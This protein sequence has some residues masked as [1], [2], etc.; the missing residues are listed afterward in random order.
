[1]GAM[2]ATN[3]LKGDQNNIRNNLVTIATQDS[4]L[5][6][7]LET[8]RRRDNQFSKRANDG[9]PR[10]RKSTPGDLPY[11]YLSSHTKQLHYS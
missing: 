8:E 7:S 4:G 1:M 5:N 10:G 2:R 9:F 11:F 6:V 3:G